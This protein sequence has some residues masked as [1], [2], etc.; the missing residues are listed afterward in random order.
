MEEKRMSRLINENLI[1]LNLEAGNK[2]EVLVKLAEL[3]QN[4]K[5][6]NC[7]WKENDLENCQGCSFCHTKGFITA[8]KEREESYPTSVGY[9]FAIPHG[10]CNSVTESGIAFA[11]LE[12]E[13]EW[14]EDEE[15][16]YVF[17][18]AVSE[19][20]ASNEHLEILIKLSKSILDDDFREQLEKTDSKSE[21]LE[22]L[23]RYTA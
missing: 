10:K 8:L 2:E 22:L 18:I 11:R 6:L 15:V 9:S 3:I 17:M 16:K 5:K 23:D 7:V 20:N 21:V 12:K 1:S 19:E 13:I 14:D 4:D